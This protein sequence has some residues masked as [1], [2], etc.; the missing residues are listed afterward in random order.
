MTNKRNLVLLETHYRKLNFKKCQ[1][2]Q[3][4]LKIKGSDQNFLKFNFKLKLSH[5]KK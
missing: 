4:L 1:F 3:Y 2:F 5:L